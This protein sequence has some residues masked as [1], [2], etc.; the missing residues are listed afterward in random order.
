MDLMVSSI[1]HSVFLRASDLEFS[2]EV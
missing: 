1:V 2:Y